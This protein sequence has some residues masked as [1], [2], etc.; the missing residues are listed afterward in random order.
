MGIIAQHVNK[1]RLEAQLQELSM[2]GYDPD[3]GRTRL[4]YTK[5][6]R[7]AVELVKGYMESAG[8]LVSFDQFGNL[9]GRLPG[10]SQSLPV[11]MSGSHVDTVINGGAFDGT[12]G[13]L[14]AIEALRVIKENNIPHNHD[15]VVGVFVSEEAARFGAGTLGSKAF[16]GDYTRADLDRLKDRDGV[17]LAKALQEWGFDPDLLHTVKGNGSEIKCFVE[18]HIEQSINLEVNKIAIGVVDQIAAPT[19]LRM[20][21]KGKAGHAGATPMN[22]RT[23]AFMAA[24]E[25]ALA[26]ETI[27]NTIGKE[28]V[29]TVGEVFVN[30]NAINVIPGEV[31]LG[32]DIRDVT[33]ERKDLAIEQLYNTVEEV[34]AKRGVTIETEE[35]ARQEP[36]KTASLIVN[37][38]RETC[39]DLGF[40]YMNVTSGAY[41]DALN[42]A[43]ITDIGMIF[44][45]SVDGVS[46]APEEFTHIEDI[47]RGAQVLAE[48]LVK[49]A[50]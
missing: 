15:L 13:T 35:I 42:M 31:V 16:V 17:T 9:F 33:T 38:I 32:I 2:I 48:T 24:A 49:L 50:K 23:D 29:G 22:L 45:P 37:T 5:P 19:N 44:V 40:S 1:E 14:S 43:K 39:E 8:L 20:T 47:H 21:I 10:N 41:H 30:P 27:A 7:E 36:V 46:H 18:L 6:E 3:K 25:I 28:T 4:P 34:S 12:I 11:V 26:I